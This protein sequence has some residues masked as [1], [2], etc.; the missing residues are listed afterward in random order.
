M[1]FRLGLPRPKKRLTELLYRTAQQPGVSSDTHQKMLSMKFLR[2]PLQI[3]QE[4]G[5]LKVT[6]G[7]NELCSETERVTD[8]GRKEVE[9]CDLVFRSVGYKGKKLFPELPFDEER[10]IIPNKNGKV[11]HG[12]LVLKNT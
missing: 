1:D 10:G 3:D 2:S 4:A 6:F 8:T 7:I 5:R 9:I 11:Q 12:K